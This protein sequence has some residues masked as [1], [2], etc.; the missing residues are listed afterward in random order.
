MKGIPTQELILAG[1]LNVHIGK[2]TG[3]KRWHGGWTI[4]DRND[5]GERVLQMAQTY[6]L[7]LVN[8]FAKKE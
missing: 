3:M 7:A 8:F 1:D 2:R 5:K 6:D 4:G